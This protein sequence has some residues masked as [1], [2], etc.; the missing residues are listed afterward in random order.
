ML[1][2]ALLCVV[3]QSAYAADSAEKEFT[4]PSNFTARVE[5]DHIHFRLLLAAD[6][7]VNRW[8]AVNDGK[9]PCAIVS[10][11]QKNSVK[12]EEE[13]IFSFNGVS[14][15][16]EYYI[17]VEQ[18]IVVVKNDLRVKNYVIKGLPTPG[19]EWRS[20]TGNTE[21]LNFLEF[22]WYPPSIWIEEREITNILIDLYYD[23]TWG[24]SPD[25]RKF[26]NAGGKFSA[27]PSATVEIG[28]MNPNKE[29]A[30][31]GKLLKVNYSSQETPLTCT[32]SLT[33]DKKF[34]VADGVLPFVYEAKD[35]ATEN[36]S[37]V[38]TYERPNEYFDEAEYNTLSSKSNVITIPA[39]HRIHN[40]GIDHSASSPRLTWEMHDIDQTEYQKSDAFVIQYS[41]SP[42][43][44]ESKDTVIN[45]VVGER[46]SEDN[47]DF[48]SEIANNTQKF[49]CKLLG[50]NEGAIYYYRIQ[51]KS[52]E[53]LGWLHSLV[54]STSTNKFISELC[55]SV[56]SNSTEARNN[57]L[58]RGYKLLDYNLNHGVKGSYVYIGYKDSDN[59]INAISRISIRRGPKWSADK[60]CTYQEVYDNKD[61]YTM[62]AVPAIGIKGG[63]LNEGVAGADS[64]YL[65]FS[66]DNIKGKNNTVIT[67]ILHTGSVAESLPSGIRTV[68]ESITDDKT[69]I[70]NNSATAI[71]LNSGCPTGTEEIKLVCQMHE[72]VSDYR[73]TQ[74]GDD[75]YMGHTCCGVFINGAFNEGIFEI[76]SA[77]E[78][79][80]FA[81]L[82]N[83]AHMTEIK[84]KLTTDIVL[85]EGVTVVNDNNILTSQLNPSESKV[86]AFR[87]WEPIGKDGHAFKGQFFGNGY[88]ISG[89]Y[90]SRSDEA[91]LFDQ[92]SGPAVV[93]DVI[94]KDSY[95]YSEEKT[96][97]GICSTARTSSNEAITIKN[98]TFDGVITGHDRIGGIVGN[99][100]VTNINIE[101]CAVR[102]VIHSD[103]CISMGGL[104]GTTQPNVPNQYNS[105]KYIPNVKNCYSYVAFAGKALSTPDVGVGGLIGKSL[106]EQAK[107][108][109]CH[110]LDNQNIL[111]LFAD[112]AKASYCDELTN[113]HSK[114]KFANGK[115]AFLLNKTH[116]QP[117]WAQKV[118]DDPY[119]VFFDDKH[120]ADKATVYMVE[121]YTCYDKNISAET[122]FY[123][124]RSDEPALLVHNGEHKDAKQPTCV[125]DGWLEYWECKN[126]D[127]K[128]SNE[129]CTTIIS[130]VPELYAT[131]QHDFDVYGETCVNCGKTR[132]QIEEEAAAIEA[133]E[134]DGIESQMFD[135]QGRRV[136]ELHR[137]ITLIK[138][139]DGKI[140][141]VLK[142]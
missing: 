30:M 35:K 51:R 107:I 27:V 56:F 83:V 128:F 54:A 14:G 138:G 103:S 102:G 6:N 12:P 118:N 124:N 45:F 1:L 101:N 110:C 39:Y 3:G 44:S 105:S 93:S 100:V 9:V 104:I 43:F 89:L 90:C 49:Y 52:T 38:F 88:T 125:Q 86:K 126:C 20:T 141:K 28:D 133:I 142:K 69:H 2:L 64:L 32:S 33:G 119:P 78:L 84:A 82:V 55:V 5:G 98:C 91:G 114:E 134:A 95:I 23:H 57:L 13:K 92:L 66:R 106:N 135:L 24:L 40:F 116:E 129:E 29:Q 42:N 85:N 15:K 73:G 132:L 139:A 97:G 4:K 140:H 36:V 48:S 58:N 47:K 53:T 31:E 99:V 127:T 121:G 70:T 80:A 113:R 76:S 63:N 130:K 60:N 71:D 75:I 115:V 77:D 19:W 112:G 17:R 137:G 34:D 11:K 68:G 21:D 122:G 108:E 96:C 94:L 61:V 22:D 37:Y 120:T 136:S 10:Y 111:G 79:Y 62:M 8:A 67:R 117:L 41:T 81:E 74:V 65:Y 59:P 50:E 87:R 123:T 72:H 25:H 46:T 16:K 18:G 7:G 109:N 26:D 131:A